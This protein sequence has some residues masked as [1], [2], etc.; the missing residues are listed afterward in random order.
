[1]V[2]GEKAGDGHFGNRPRRRIEPQER[3]VCGVASADW[4]G[5]GIPEEPDDYVVK[6]GPGMGNPIGP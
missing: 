3:M 2:S 4:D 5:A 6:A 1:M